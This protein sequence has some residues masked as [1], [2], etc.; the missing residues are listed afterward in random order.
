[1]KKLFIALALLFAPT[2][3]GASNRNPYLDLFRL[4]PITY[5]RAPNVPLIQN[6]EAMREPSYKPARRMIVDA[7]S[8][9]VPNDEAIDAIAEACPRVA[10]FGAGTGY[11][12]W[13]LS[14]RDVEVRAA[15]DWSW[16]KTEHLWFPV[17]TGSYSWLDQ[18]DASWC[19]L[20]VW[21]PQG[22]MASE[23]IRHWH[24]RTLV[25]VGEPDVEG[26]R[27]SNGSRGFFAALHD[28][29]TLKQ[30]VAIPQWWNHSD[31]VFIWE[32]P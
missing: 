24:G 30:T 28:G 11:W 20:L 9:A 7:F 27:R 3:V 25:Y 19:L 29:F 13:L 22:E 8:W 26:H 1:M 18:F 5:W 6:G 21:P 14:G 31:A 17:E 12:S 2:L 16:G 23:A 15:D 10:D 4:A 32:R